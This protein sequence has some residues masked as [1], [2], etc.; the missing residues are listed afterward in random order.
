M[1]ELIR[2]SNHGEKKLKLRRGSCIAASQ[3]P[4]G[5]KPTTQITFKLSAERNGSTSRQEAAI[6]DAKTDSGSDEME[7]LELKMSRTL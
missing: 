1:A 5:S 7:E 3:V 4:D 2:T 6:S